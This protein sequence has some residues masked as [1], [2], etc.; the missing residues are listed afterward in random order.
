M[1]LAGRKALVKVS[2]TAVAFTDEA[3]TANAERTRYQVTNAVKRVFDPTAAIVVERDTGGGFGVVS[4]A[5]YTLNRLKGTVVFTSVQPVGTVVRVDGSYLPLSTAAEATSYE[6]AI[7]A[8]NGDASYFGD[9]WMRRQQVSLKFTGSIGQWRTT[10]TYMETKLLAGDPVVVE[11][12]ADASTD[13]EASA[14]VVLN[15]QQIRAVTRGFVEQNV[16]FE[17]TKDA[18]GHVVSYDDTVAVPPS[19]LPAGNE[20]L[21]TTLGTG[22]V[23]AFYDARNNVIHTAGVVETWDDTRGTSGFGPQLVANTGERPTIAGDLITF[24]GAT[25]YMATAASALFDLSVAKSIIVIGSIDVGA[26]TAEYIA[27]ICDS[28]SAIRVMTVGSSATDNLQAVYGPSSGYTVLDI[29][30]DTPAPI[31][32]VSP[33]RWLL[34]VSKDATTGLQTRIADSPVTT[35]TAS[36]NQASGNNRLSLGTLFPG[37]GIATITLRVVM[38]LDRA[39]TTS[40]YNA[41]RAYALAQHSIV[42]T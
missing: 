13:P 34:M 12:Y 27:S 6:W 3:T 7:G 32:V 28:L 23:L 29:R 10:D 18:D 42:E 19:L 25:D 39:F 16:T 17:G 2:G 24:D 35:G 30:D 8:E 40:D 22:A 14:L 36:G 1:A 20:S 4:T 41:I 31:P 5:E 37:G 38:V 15:Q 9:D 11:F 21:L 33:V 26:A